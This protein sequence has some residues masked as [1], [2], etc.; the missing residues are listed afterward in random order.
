MGSCMGPHCALWIVVWVHSVHYGLFYGSTV[1]TMDKGLF[2]F[3]KQGLQFFFPKTD[4]E[5]IISIQLSQFIA[6][7]QKN[8]QSLLFHESLLL[9]LLFWYT[10]S[11]IP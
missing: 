10:E 11:F 8:A 9:F 5:S 7:S 1:C 4:T 3:L 2:F 6:F